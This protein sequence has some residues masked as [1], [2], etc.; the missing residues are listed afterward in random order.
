MDGLMLMKGVPSTGLAVGRDVA[1]R[2]HLPAAKVYALGPRAAAGS[3]GNTV[4]ASA[5]CVAAKRSYVFPL[6]LRRLWPDEGEAVADKGSDEVAA[7]EKVEKSVALEEEEQEAVTEVAEHR[8]DNWVLKILRVTSMWAE[9]GEPEAGGDREVAAVEDGDR[10]VG[11][12]SSLE[13]GSEGCVVED[14]EEEKKVFDR[15]S[16]SRLLRRVSLAEAE[17]YA[18]MAY[19]G[20][21]AYIVSKIKVPN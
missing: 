16:F 18:K 2:H 19:L 7:A 8:R 15:E 17:L 13:D 6:R 9:R 14:E 5:P 10:C 4:E 12:E 20:S 3:D 21:L 1:A 11:C